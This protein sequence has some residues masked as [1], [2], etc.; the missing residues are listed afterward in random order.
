MAGSI[1]YAESLPRPVGVVEYT[2]IDGA[3]LGGEGGES[4]NTGIRLARAR[5]VRSAA[6]VG[7]AQSIHQH[8]SYPNNSGQG[9]SLHMLY[10]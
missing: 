2:N 5:T 8:Y 6:E 7:S 1:R 9:G 4:E 10:G 3:M